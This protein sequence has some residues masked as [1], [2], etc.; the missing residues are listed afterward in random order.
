MINIVIII[1]L[2]C[3]SGLVP[4]VVFFIIFTSLQF[5]RGVIIVVD[6]ITLIEDIGNQIQDKP[7]MIYLEIF[8]RQYVPAELKSH[9]LI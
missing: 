5:P 2:Y 4:S 3:I 6:F 9:M 1:L 8:N 7:W